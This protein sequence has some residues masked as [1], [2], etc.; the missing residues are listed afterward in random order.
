MP[1]GQRLAV[2]R[3]Q[4]QTVGVANGLRAVAVELHLIEPAC[5]F[6]QPLDGKAFQLGGVKANGA[7][8]ACSLHPVE[9]RGLAVSES[10]SRRPGLMSV[11]CQRAKRPA[12][13]GIAY[14]T[15]AYTW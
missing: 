15:S 1:R 12:F 13:A 4:L 11:N 5:T 9:G 10:A 2:A 14:P 3:K 6:R 8:I 7:G